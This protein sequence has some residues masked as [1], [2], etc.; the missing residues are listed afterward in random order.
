M[1]QN[2]MTSEE[3]IAFMEKVLIDKM[4]KLIRGKVHDYTGDKGPF[5]NYER[6]EDLGITRLTGLMVRFLDKVERVLTHIKKGELQVP[7]EGLDDCF[8]DFI[9]YSVSALGMIEE[10]KNNADK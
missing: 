2:K 3:Y 4:P 10:E 9:G 6:S 8:Y 7:G 5:G 1:K